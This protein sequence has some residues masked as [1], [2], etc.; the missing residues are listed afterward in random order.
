MKC[1]V[2]WTCMSHCMLLKEGELPTK[3]SIKSIFIIDLFDIL[4]N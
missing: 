2:K 4:I 1:G 3:N